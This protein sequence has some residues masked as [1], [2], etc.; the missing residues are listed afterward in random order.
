MEAEVL[1]SMRFAHLRVLSSR[2]E[3]KR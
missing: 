2:G 1:V 3:I